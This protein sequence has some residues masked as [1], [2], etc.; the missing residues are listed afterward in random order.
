[1]YSL[2]LWSDLSR[3]KLKACKAV[4]GTQTQNAQ[5]SQESS[6]LIAI[7]LLLSFTFRCLDAHFLVVLLEGSEI[8][9]SLTELTFFHS[10]SDIPMNEC[11]LAVHEIELVVDAGE[12]LGDSSRVGNHAA[13]AH[14]LRQVTPWNDRRR[15]I[16]DSTF[17]ASR[18]PVHKLNGTLGL[19]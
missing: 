9:A 6:E 10:L 15:L 4:S 7:A 19:D 12:H 16:I 11:T 2:S 13:R 8:L 5:G 17:K 14:D 18:R 1:M 3:F